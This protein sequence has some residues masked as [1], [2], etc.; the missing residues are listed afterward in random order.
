[1][2]LYTVKVI[3]QGTR[4]RECW[5]VA[6]LYWMI[7]DRFTDTVIFELKYAGNKGARCGY[8]RGTRILGRVNSKSKGPE[9]ATCLLC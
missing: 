9:L 3:R 4:T 5:Q 2:L 7:N 8:L 6:I 1:M